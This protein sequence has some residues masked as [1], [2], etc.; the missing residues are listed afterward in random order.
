MHHRDFQLRHSHSRTSEGSVINR[1]AILLFLLAGLCGT[2]SAQISG[3]GQLGCNAAP[4]TGSA[5]SSATAVNTTQVLA[6]SVSG[7]SV[8]VTLDQTSTLTAGAITFLGSPGDGNF[9]TLAAW[10]VVDPT[11][12]PFAAIANPYTLV[13]N[14]NKQFEIQMGGMSQLEVKLTTAIAGTGTI[15]PYATIVCY[16]FLQVFQPLNSNLNAS[17]TFPAPQAVTQS[18]GPWASNVTQIA[19]SAVVADPCQVNA[20]SSV[21]INLTASGQLI[22]G[23]SGKQTYVCSMDII[24]ASAQNIALVEGTGTVCATG[25]AG[26]AGGTTAATGWNFAANGGLVKGVGSNWVFKTATAADNVCLLLSG[27]GQ[28]SGSV[29]YV[30]Q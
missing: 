3:A 23:T 14:T 10:Q 2:A 21:N 12:A 6:S 22:T 25:I 9:V 8:L 5:W 30:Q 1:I 4:T 11:A 17:V 13:A 18:S 16:Q 7:A 19:G 28:T 27:T 24:T 15:T 29:Q 20:R 26:M